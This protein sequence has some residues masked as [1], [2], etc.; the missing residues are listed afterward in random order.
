MK[1]NIIRQV[2]EELDLP[3]GKAKCIVEAIIQEIKYGII[4]D[5]SVTIRGFGS[6]KVLTKKERLGR[7]PKTGEAAVISARKVSSFKAS[8]LFK[9]KVNDSIPS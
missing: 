3:V 8:K 6:F 1:S 4:N 7:N 5:N 9:T 2:S